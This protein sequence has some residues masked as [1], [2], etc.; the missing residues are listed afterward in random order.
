MLKKIVTSLCL[1]FILGAYTAPVPINS[2]GYWEGE[3]E[4]IFD[5]ALCESI[6][7]FLESEKVT[8]AVDFGCGDGSYVNF[9]RSKGLNVVGYDG[10][11]ETRLMGGEYCSQLDLAV[12]Q[13]LGKTFEWVISLEVAEHLPREFEEIYL[14]NLDRHNTK[15]IILSWAVPGQAGH[16]HFNCRSQ[17]YVIEKLKAMGYELDQ[18]VTD[19]FKESATLWWFKRNVMVFRKVPTATFSQ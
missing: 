2:H 18:R 6:A 12:G 5:P 11:P 15:G 3:T 8:S 14:S 19:M 17:A 13:N 1:T 4:H 9:L 7:E 16:G 10:N